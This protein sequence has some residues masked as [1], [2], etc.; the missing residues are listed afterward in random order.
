MTPA[1][2]ATAR[3]S[4]SDVAPEEAAVTGRIEASSAAM[5]ASGSVTRCRD[6]DSTA[7]TSGGRIAAL[8][9]TM[10]GSPAVSA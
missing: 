2:S 3:A 9:P 7:N 1:S 6:P 8:I 5:V 10:T 4:S